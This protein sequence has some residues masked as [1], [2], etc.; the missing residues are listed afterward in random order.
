MF[1]VFHEARA[2][3]VLPHSAGLAKGGLGVVHLFG[4]AAS[5]DVNAVVLTHEVLHALGAR[6]R[7]DA[8]GLPVP[9][10][11][12]G[13]P[14]QAPLYPQARAEI[15]AGTI[16]LSPTEARLPDGLGQCVVGP[17]TAAEVGW[18]AE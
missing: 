2:G 12:L 8:A 18:R 13:D 15:M 5:D 3:R 4:R 9:P 17:R 16:A 11:G 14:G 10:D 1:L 7:Y 6:D